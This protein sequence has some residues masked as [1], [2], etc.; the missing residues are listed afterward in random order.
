MTNKDLEVINASGEL[1]DLTLTGTA[2]APVVVATTQL[3]I[4]GNKAL[5]KSSTQLNLGRG[6]SSIGLLQ[7]V[8]FKPQ[9]E[10]SSPQEGMVYFDS[11]AK[12]LKYYN[13]ETWQNV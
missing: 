7:A 2:T 8:V 5:D 9:A 3:S 4:D 6:F 13:G 1:E 10:P 12:V 11:T